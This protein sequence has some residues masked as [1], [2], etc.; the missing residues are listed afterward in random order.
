MIL[1]PHKHA[2]LQHK[3]DK[4]PKAGGSYADRMSC[5]D[6]QL[7][8]CHEVIVEFPV[9]HTW[10]KYQFLNYLYVYLVKEVMYTYKYIDGSFA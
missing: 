7:T 1:P 10:T 4:C 8:P 9:L 5:Q 2:G 3:P 6:F